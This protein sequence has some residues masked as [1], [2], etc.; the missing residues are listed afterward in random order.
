MTKDG[1]FYLIFSRKSKHF[2]LSCFKFGGGYDDDA[3]RATRPRFLIKAALTK[4]CDNIVT[5]CD[6]EECD[7]SWS[8]VVSVYSNNVKVGS[9]PAIID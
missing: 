5:S 6:A 4:S 1:F 9:D 2:N 7:V 3:T 8:Y